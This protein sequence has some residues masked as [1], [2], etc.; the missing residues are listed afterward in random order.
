LVQKIKSLFDEAGVKYEY[1]KHAPVKTSEE[2][3]EVRG[4]KVGRRP[5]S[6]DSERQEIR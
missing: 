6:A 1:Q 4:T 2:A 5:K 3:A